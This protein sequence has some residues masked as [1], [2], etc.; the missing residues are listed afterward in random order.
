[1]WAFLLAIL[2]QPQVAVDTVA[3]LERNHFYDNEARLIFIQI[4][5]WERDHHVRFWVL[6]KEHRIQK[7]FTG[8]YVL[9]FDDAGIMR[10]IRSPN[11]NETWTQEDPELLD[12]DLLPK[13]DRRPLSRMLNNE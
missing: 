10:E 2:P 4:I 1:M 5:G 8:G 6:E 12:R 13:A 9:R 7:D 3:C 11:Y